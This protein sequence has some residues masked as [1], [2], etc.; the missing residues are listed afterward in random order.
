MVPREAAVTA[1][2]AVAACADVGGELPDGLT[3]RQFETLPGVQ[4]AMD[5]E[6]LN[7]IWVTNPTDYGVILLTS[8][9]GFV[10]RDPAELHQFR[11]VTPLVS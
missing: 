10:I 9:G 1:P 2:E 7:Q 3:L 6:W 11:C 4:V 8:E 5:G